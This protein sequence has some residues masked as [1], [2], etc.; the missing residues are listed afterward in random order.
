MTHVYFEQQAVKV[1]NIYCIGR[2]Y[3]EH[4]AEFH[5]ETPSEPVVFLKPNNSLLNQGGIINLPA[6][7]QSVHYECELVLLIG[8]DA[9]GNIP[10]DPVITEASSVSISPNRFSV[11]STSKRLGH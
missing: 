8:Q 10:K 7:S 5:N 6:Y 11:T 1:N 3:V 2:N 9:D 4:I